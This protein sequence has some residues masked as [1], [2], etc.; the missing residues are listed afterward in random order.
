[1]STRSRRSSERAG[2]SAATP[3]APTSLLKQLFNRV[4]VGGINGDAE[5][6]YS[7]GDRPFAAYM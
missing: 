3:P 1:M 5:G 4:G 2:M 6:N 7:Y